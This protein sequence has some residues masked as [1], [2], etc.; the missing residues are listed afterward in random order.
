MPFILL[1]H[2][3]TADGPWQEKA[4][5]SELLQLL[6]KVLIKPIKTQL[7]AAYKPG[8]TLV[9]LPHEVSCNTYLSVA[10]CFKNPLNLCGELDIEF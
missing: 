4:A 10:I 2:C 6:F 9:F 3:V 7:D 1:L 5:I 8:D